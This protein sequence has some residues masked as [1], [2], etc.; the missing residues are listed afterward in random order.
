MAHSGGT[1]TVHEKVAR[2]WQNHGRLGESAER[3]LQSG[4]LP[5][6]AAQGEFY[7]SF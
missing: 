7:D 3:R 4:G 1:T 2:R 5:Y 6:D